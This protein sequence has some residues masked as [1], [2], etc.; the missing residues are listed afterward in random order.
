MAVRTWNAG[1]Y[2]SGRIMFGQICLGLHLED[3]GANFTTLH[4]SEFSN[5][6]ICVFVVGKYQDMVGT[7]KVIVN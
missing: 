6:E 2:E 1:I 3:V 5:P 4:L 7:Q